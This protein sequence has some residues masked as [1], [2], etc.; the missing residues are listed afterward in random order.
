VRMFCARLAAS[1]V[2]AVSLV[3]VYR[4]ARGIAA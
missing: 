3:A 2:L 1:T 4:I